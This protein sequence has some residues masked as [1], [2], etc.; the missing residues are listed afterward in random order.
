LLGGFHL[1]FLVAGACPAVAFLAAAL[2]L[3]SRRAGIEAEV[4]AEA[5]AMTFLE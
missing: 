3:R 5:E 4:L 1:G 2:L